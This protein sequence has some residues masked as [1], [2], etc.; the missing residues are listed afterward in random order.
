MSVLVETAPHVME[1]EEGV[2]AIVLDEYKIAFDELSSK[3]L[4]SHTIESYQ[5]L[6]LNTR[7]DDVAIKIKEECIYKI[8][9]YYTE[10]RMFDN[11]MNI[12]KSN[13]SFFGEIA[14]AKTAK[15]VR[16]I[17]NIVAD[18]PDSLDV[19]VSLCYDVVA[20]CKAEKRTFLRQRIEAKLASLLLQKKDTN[21][22]LSIINGL[23]SELKKLDDKQMLTETHL[24]EARIYHSLR[25]I[26][27]SKASLT[28]SRT[29]ANAIYVAP[30]LQAELDEMSGT[31]HCEEG[32]YTTAY[33]YFLEGFDAYDQSN[34]KVNAVVCLKYMSL[35]KILNNTPEEVAP[36]L[37][38]KYGLKHGG[39]HIDAMLAVAKAAKS[40][41]LEDYKKAVEE[42]SVILKSDD[43]IA[44]HID[45]LYEKML[46][47]NLLKIIHP[48][49][50]VEISYVAKKM[51][52]P[53][54]QVEKKLS[55][56]IL[57]HRFSGILDQGK[58]HLVIYED[59]GEDV[60]Y[61]K[62]IEIITNIGLVVE[63]LTSRAKGEAKKTP[64]PTE[65]EKK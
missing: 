62:S 24:T 33:S 31:L 41:S 49:S 9:R 63:T 60:S 40:K 34:D 25:N 18:V 1:L 14:K 12:L 5:E 23:L 11:V 42:H 54:I 20:W 8:T 29:A 64:D 39:P 46:E 15:I 30:S 32:D 16:N 3:P 48:Y 35:C 61:S 27:K 37:S 6:L 53:E 17:L 28:A 52:L 4:S 26:P 10:S 19:Q 50:C 45:L 44:H 56:M 36:L 51:N 58:G 59:S 21:S 57:D 43:L 22:S 65:K 13:N 55:Q 47:S 2:E 38:G 7:L